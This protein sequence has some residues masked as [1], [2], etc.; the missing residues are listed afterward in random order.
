MR[1]AGSELRPK[2]LR[3]NRLA[4]PTVS[5]SCCVALLWSSPLLALRH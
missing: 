2:S 5:K 1:L 3:P 4:D